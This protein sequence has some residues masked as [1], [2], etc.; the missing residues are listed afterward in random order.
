M[1]FEDFLVEPLICADRRIVE[2]PEGHLEGARNFIH[3]LERKADRCDGLGHLHG[4]ALCS[5][6]ETKNL[7]QPLA[8]FLCLLGCI[9]HGLKPLCGLLGLLGTLL[10]LSG[11]RTGHIAPAPRW[12][13]P[14]PAAAKVDLAS[15]R[16]QLR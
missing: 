9:A 14:A 12:C 8:L 13:A 2:P 10:G 7:P 11:G 5:L 6:Q 1:G 3:P 16:S 4:P 15:N